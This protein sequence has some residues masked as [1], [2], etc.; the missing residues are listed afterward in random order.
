MS[1]FFKLRK[2]GKFTPTH[3]IILLILAYL[4]LATTAY[5]YRDTPEEFYR[6]FAPFYEEMI[7]RGLI[8][9]GLLSF[10]NKKIAIFLSSFLFGLWHLKN[11][12]IYSTQALIYQILYAGLLIGP[13][14]A[15]LTIRTKSIWPGVLIHTF[16]NLLSPLSWWLLS[17]FLS[18]SS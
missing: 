17:F 7:F 1:E 5:F 14:L 10:C 3:Q 8:L 11:L 4:S 6:Y 2:I 18:P 12:S 16:N 13:L 15:W 9:G